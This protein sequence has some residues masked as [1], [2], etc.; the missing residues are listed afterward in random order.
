MERQRES[1]L[2]RVCSL[3]FSDWRL[4]QRRN[5]RLAPQVEAAIPTTTDGDL[6]LAVE[7]LALDR[8]GMTPDAEATPDDVGLTPGAVGMMPSVVG[9]TPI[10]AEMKKGVGGMMMV[11]TSIPTTTPPGAA[12]EVAELDSLE[13]QM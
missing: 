7:D 6:A 3:A 4:D 10:D 13:Q 9:M 2:M 8:G 12:D 1:L 5:R 11:T